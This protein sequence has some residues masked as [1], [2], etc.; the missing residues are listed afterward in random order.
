MDDER[1]AHLAERN[2]I[3]DHPAILPVRVT[4]RRLAGG[5]FD[6]RD[7][8]ELELQC[9][10]LADRQLQPMPE[11][12]AHDAAVRDE[13]D[14][15]A[16]QCGRA[17]D[18]ARLQ[19]GGRFAARRREIEHV[20]GPGVE[21]RAVDLGPRP[22]LPLAEVDFGEARVDLRRRVQRFGE[23]PRALQRAAED[24]DAGRQERAQAFGGA[25]RIFARHV[26]AAVADAGGE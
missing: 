22:A 7:A 4:Q 10:P 25:L 3:F 24:R 8:G 11:Q 14:G 13:G 12:C 2:G 18:G 15:V 6:Q 5:Q 23:A 17:L 16:A 26:E 1:A 9:A 19:P 21:Q 20:G